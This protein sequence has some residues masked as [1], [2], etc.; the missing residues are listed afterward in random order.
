MQDISE[1]SF[2]ASNPLHMATLLRETPLS[3]RYEDSDEREVQSTQAG[4]DEEAPLL[5]KNN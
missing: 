3:N 5:K 1:E 4:D 2:E